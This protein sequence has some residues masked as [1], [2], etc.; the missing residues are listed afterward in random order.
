MVASPDRVVTDHITFIVVVLI[1]EL[2]R[3]MRTNDASKGPHESQKNV[4][5]PLRLNG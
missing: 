4:V 5:T 1:L 3:I 2:Q